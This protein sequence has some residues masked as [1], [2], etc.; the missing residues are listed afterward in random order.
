M[1]DIE[2]TLAARVRE[3]RKKRGLSQEQLAVQ[4][5][6]HPRYVGQL[7]R[8]ERGASLW[9][10]SLLAGSLGVPLSALIGGSEPRP[11]CNPAVARIV[12]ILQRCRGG[13]LAVVEKVLRIVFSPKRSRAGAT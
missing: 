7:E 3:L 4:A 5:G 11:A 1:A 13:D 10:V 12:A 6:L 2:E 9:A 8:R